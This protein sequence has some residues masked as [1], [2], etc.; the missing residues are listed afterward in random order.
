MH[1]VICAL[2]L[3]LAL[4]GSLF[5]LTSVEAGSNPRG[6]DRADPS[7]EASPRELL[8][9]NA[10]AAY[11]LPFGPNRRRRPR[12]AFNNAAR[13]GQ[14]SKTFNATAKK[15]RVRRIFNET[16]D[17]SGAKGRSLQIPPPRVDGTKKKKTKPLPG[18]RL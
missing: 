4:A 12:A 18:P 2:A 9:T 8:M 16:G 14:L 15:R 6:D 1:R 7:A 10:H 5:N 13:K 17:K 11:Y 3:A